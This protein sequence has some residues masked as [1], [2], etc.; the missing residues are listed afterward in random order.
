MRTAVI[1]GVLVATVPCAAQ[2]REP[3]PPPR[4]G[5]EADKR[6]QELG[7]RFDAYVRL[8]TDR[9]AADPETVRQL[10]RLAVE[11]EFIVSGDTATVSHKEVKGRQVFLRKIASR[12]FMQDRQKQAK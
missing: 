12:W 3:P 1:L 4:Y 7:G 5:I 8:I 6:L 2:N 11:G 10:R 9:L